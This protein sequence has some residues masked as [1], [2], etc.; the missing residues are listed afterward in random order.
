[1]SL[2]GPLSL[3]LEIIMVKCYNNHYV[4][5]QDGALLCFTS[6]QLYRGFLSLLNYKLVDMINFLVFLSLRH[7]PYFYEI[8]KIFL[9]WIA[10]LFW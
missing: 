5:S 4:K 7:M 9:N 8:C 6:A 3:A 10:P 1:M 2:E